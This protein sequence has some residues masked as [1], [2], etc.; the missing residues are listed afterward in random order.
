MTLIYTQ[1]SKLGIILAADSNLTSNSGST[2]L[3]DKG[4]GFQGVQLLR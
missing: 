4:Q 2:A 3:G 1:V